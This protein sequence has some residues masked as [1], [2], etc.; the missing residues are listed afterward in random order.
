MPGTGEQL[1]WSCWSLSTGPPPRRQVWEEQVV[2]SC[3]SLSTGPPPRRQVWGEQVVRSCWSLLTG[4]PLL[5]DLDVGQHKFG[6]KNGTQLPKLSS[7]HKSFV[8]W[9]QNKQDN[10][11]RGAPRGSTKK[12]P[13]DHDPPPP[14]MMRLLQNNSYFFGLL[15]LLFFFG[16]RALRR[17]FGDGG[18]LPHP[19]FEKV[20]IQFPRPPRAVDTTTSLEYIKKDPQ[21]LLYADPVSSPP[22]HSPHDLVPPHPS[23]LLVPPPQYYRSPTSSPPPVISHSS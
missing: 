23:T 13:L 16:C 10:F 3:W 20:R 12:Q 18:V 6:H 2:R 11:F 9:S 5:F 8:L 19:G 7:L 1:V 14:I 21:Y 4:V 22:S 15:L 17:F